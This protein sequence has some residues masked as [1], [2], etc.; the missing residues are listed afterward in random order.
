MRIT[1]NFFLNKKIIKIFLKRAK[2]RKREM[3]KY[4]DFIMI[5][6]LGSFQDLLQMTTWIKF[7]TIFQF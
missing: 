3:D 6:E 2:R 7:T 5:L 1:R 4:Q